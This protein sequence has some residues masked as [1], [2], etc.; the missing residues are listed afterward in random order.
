M[1]WLVSLHFKPVVVTYMSSH[2]KISNHKIYRKLR[3]L[4]KKTDD[5]S[6]ERMEFLR[7]RFGKCTDHGY[8]C[9]VEMS[10]AGCCI[11]GEFLRITLQSK[12]VNVT[13]RELTTRYSLC[14]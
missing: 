12:F 6:R 4:S 11:C 2:S 14:R 8:R 5:A 3:E 9:D 7:I 1:S 13:P 10:K